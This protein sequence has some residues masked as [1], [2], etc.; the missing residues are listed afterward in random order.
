MLGGG[1]GDATRRG[2]VDG[3]GMAPTWGDPVGVALGWG[4]S[5]GVKVDVSSPKPA[6]VALAA[7]SVV[8][9]AVPLATGAAATALVALT[10]RPTR[11][12]KRASASTRCC[13]DDRLINAG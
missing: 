9:G 4:D 11:R 1:G 12:V 5:V 13:M 3:E 10:P 2:T 7:I 6:A 8:V